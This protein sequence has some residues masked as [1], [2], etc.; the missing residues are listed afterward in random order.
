[1]GRTLNSLYRER[2]TMKKIALL[3]LLTLAILQPLAEAQRGVPGVRQTRFG[4]LLENLHPKGVGGLKNT[5][6]NYGVSCSLNNALPRVPVTTVNTP[7][8]CG[9]N[10]Q[11]NLDKCKAWTMIPK[12]PAPDARCFFLSSCKPKISVM[13]KGFVS[14]DRSC[15]SKPTGLPTC[16]SYDVICIDDD[17]SNNNILNESNPP[18]VKSPEECGRRCAADP[19][20]QFWTMIPNVLQPPAKCYQLSGCGR[21][22]KRD[23]AV[24][25]AATCP[26]T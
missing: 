25:G 12:G 3:S 2:R 7:S 21:A 17:N 10:C 9:L 26:P 1:M 14:G 18:I 22:R 23:G 20:C 16:P 13:F 5:C 19:S 11:G 15:P 4:D 6:P 24:S 8:E